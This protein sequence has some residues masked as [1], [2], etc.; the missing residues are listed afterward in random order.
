MHLNGY[1]KTMPDGMVE[2][3]SV[4]TDEAE[5]IESGI[6]SRLLIQVNVDDEGRKIP[7]WANR[8]QSY[9]F[10]TL[11]EQVDDEF[12]ALPG[13]H[14]NTMIDPAIADQLNCD[15][16]AKYAIAYPVTPYVQRAIS[17]QA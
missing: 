7:I 1:C 4:F 13:Y 15:E 6:A 8:C 2:F 5:A 17:C 16:I 10:G 3:C 11:Y 12:T 9:F 14:V